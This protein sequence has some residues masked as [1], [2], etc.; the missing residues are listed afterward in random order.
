MVCPSF[1]AVGGALVYGDSAR[2][3]RFC[4]RDSIKCNLTLL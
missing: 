2:N 1:F 3:F 4:A